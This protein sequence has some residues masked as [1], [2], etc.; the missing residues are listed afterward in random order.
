MNIL[1][2]GAA[3]FVGSH[4]SERLLGEG[5][6][7]VGIDCY[8]DYYLP[9]LKKM[10]A[11][12]VT[13]A[14]GEILELDLAADSLDEAVADA[15]VVF[16]LAAQPGI[17]ATTPFSDY[18]RN[19]MIATWRLL[20]ACRKVEGLKGFINVATS[21]VYGAHATDSEETPPK[22]TSYYGVTKLAAE[23]LVLA[24][25]RDKGFPGCSLRLFSVYGPR[26][27]PEKL[28]PKLIHS[29]LAGEKFPL[30]QGSKNHSRSFSY[31]DDI[32]DGFMAALNNLDKCVGEIF[33][34]GTDLEMTTGEGIAI[35]EE[36]MGKK[37]DLEMLPPRP[38][39][40]LRTH[41]NIDKA[42]RLLGYEPKTKPQDGLKAEVDWYKERVFGKFK[43]Y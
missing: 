27:R 23:Q 3:G 22:P 25:Q 40:Q 31:V 14:G 42:R 18:E 26:E 16:H 24:Y 17:N 10:N 34:I 33:N 11:E 20:E 8:N 43:I 32:I 35:V 7:V 13:H 39:D 28:Y 37:A 19:N 2:T 21:S 30:F 36:I 9:A 15:D 6:S 38:G 41:T 1:V 12:D 5:H 29:I 4:L